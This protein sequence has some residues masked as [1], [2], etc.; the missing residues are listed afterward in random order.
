[1]HVCD[2]HFLVVLELPSRDRNPCSKSHREESINQNV[3]MTVA[4]FEA[5]LGAFVLYR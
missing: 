2:R 1:M 4:V 3:C 5:A